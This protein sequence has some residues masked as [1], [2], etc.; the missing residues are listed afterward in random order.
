MLIEDSYETG[1][2]LESSEVRTS[3]SEEVALLFR[4]NYRE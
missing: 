2:R 1:K 3:P 4:A